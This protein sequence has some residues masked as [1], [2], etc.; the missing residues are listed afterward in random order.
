MLNTPT[1]AHECIYQQSLKIFLHLYGNLDYPPKF[2]HL[3]LASLST[4]PEN[5]M[6]ICG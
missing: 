3:F 2:I 5:F 1:V 4:F 6:K